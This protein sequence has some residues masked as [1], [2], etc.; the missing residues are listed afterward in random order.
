MF[1]WQL[2]LGQRCTVHAAGG[3]MSSN[4]PSSFPSNCSA[5]L[6]AG[7]FGSPL[8]KLQG[9]FTFQFRR[10]PCFF[11]CLTGL[12]EEKGSLCSLVITKGHG[13]F[14]WSLD[15][16]GIIATAQFELMLHIS[17]EFTSNMEKSGLK[18]NIR[19]NEF[20]DF[21]NFPSV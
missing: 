10:D 3:P 5:A 17:G 7:T 6:S 8:G 18:I 15:C 21:F 16:S 11:L 2:K 14:C 13:C 20:K 1:E 9:L 4:P 19:N 12:G